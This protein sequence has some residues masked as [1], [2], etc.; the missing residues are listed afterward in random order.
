MSHL[1]L[2]PIKCDIFSLGMVLL[3]AGGK[4]QD[5]ELSKLN[6]TNDENVRRLK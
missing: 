1:K 6:V 4:M 2:N 3:K 5:Q